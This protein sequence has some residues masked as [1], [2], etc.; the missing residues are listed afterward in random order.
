MYRWRANDPMRFLLTQM[1]LTSFLWD[2]G[3]QCR[4]RS[5]AASC[6]VW[7]GSS[8]FLTGFSITNRRKMKKKYTWHP[9]ND[10]WTHPMYKDG[11]SIRIIW[12]NI[13]LFMPGM[14]LNLHFVHVQRHLFPWRGPCMNNTMTLA[15]ILLNTEKFY[16]FIFIVLSYQCQKYYTDRSWKHFSTVP[17]FGR[18]IW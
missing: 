13:Y 8:L 15:T 10:K 2:I 14:N 12:V 1:S 17:G 18:L 4:P 11:K 5:D 9:L 7:S 6:G 16:T 3:K